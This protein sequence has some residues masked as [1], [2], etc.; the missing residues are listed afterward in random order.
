MKV[1]RVQKVILLFLSEAKKKKKKLDKTRAGDYFFSEGDFFF[2]EHDT[3]KMD[4]EYTKKKRE[5]K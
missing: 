5:K 1:T 4:G 2:P 3:H